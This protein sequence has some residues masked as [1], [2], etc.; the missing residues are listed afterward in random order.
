MILQHDWNRCKIVIWKNVYLEGLHALCKH[1]QSAHIPQLIP[2][3]LSARSPFC[4]H[5]GTTSPTCHSG[6]HNL[7]SCPASASNEYFQA[8]TMT[9]CNSCCRHEPPYLRNSAMKPSSPDAR[10]FCICPTHLSIS[11]LAGSISNHRACSP[12]LGMFAHT[13]SATSPAPF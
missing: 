6:G 11:Y 12:T 8:R 10:R 13:L 5:S 7:A 2:P 4:F 3:Q 9:A 1:Q